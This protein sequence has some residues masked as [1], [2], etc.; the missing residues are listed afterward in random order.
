MQVN[1]VSF[2]NS[3]ENEQKL[4]LRRKIMREYVANMSDKDLHN[5]ASESVLNSPK[6]KKNK[7][8]NNLLYYSIP[9]AA[10][11][12]AA[13]RTP[14]MFPKYFRS[15][16]LNNFATTALN[17]AWTFA[18]ID[19]TF[20]ATRYLNK[21]NK[22]AGDFSQNHPIL[23]TLA[24][25]AASVAAIFGTGKG[26][27][28]IIN[29][30]GDK[31]SI[32]DLRAFVKFNNKLN[33]SKILNN[34]SEK[35]AKV[36]KSIRNFAKTA[37]DYSPMLLIIASIANQFGTGNKI[38]AETEKSFKQLKEDRKILRE[39]IAQENACK[40]AQELNRPGVLYEV[41]PEPVAE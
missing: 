20:G 36:P 2:G 4:A 40:K 31:I 12:G 18:V 34:I 17:W 35:I 14:K 11:L 39:Q 27:S 33:S 22:K 26:I 1:A 38:S 25:V 7:K 6:A 10:G 9:L 19:M 30:F 13:I 28:K 21:H 41:K 24:T 3:A 29:K 15:M 5:L 8:L 32:K 23:S 16:K 37:I